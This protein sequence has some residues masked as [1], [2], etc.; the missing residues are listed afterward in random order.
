M[1]PFSSCLDKQQKVRE[2]FRT[3]ASPEE[4]YQRIIDLGKKSPKLSPEEKTEER[5][6]KGCQS[7]TFLKAEF[8][9]GKCFFKIDS[10]AL[11]SAGLGQLLTCVY[12]GEPPEAVIHCPP[13]F[14]EELGIIK[15]LSPSRSQGVANM[16]ARMKLEAIKFL[17]SGLTSCHWG[18]A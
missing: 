14:L 6:V 11:I 1:E 16:F 2:L 5:R 18:Q 4:M 15:S 12:N 17:G 8:V 10:E 9:E 7:R 13:K 3:A